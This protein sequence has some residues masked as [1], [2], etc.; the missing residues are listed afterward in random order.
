MRLMIV[1]SLALF[2]CLASAADVTLEWTP[3]TARVDGT[4]LPVS[5]IG[6]YSVRYKKK[7]DTAYKYVV[8]PDGKAVSYSLGALDAAEYQVSI[9]AFDVTGLYSDYSD[10]S[11]KISPAPAVPAS[12]KVKQKTVDVLAACRTAAQTCW[13]AV[14]GEWK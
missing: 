11:L 8:I 9:A 1:L 13:V 3:P 7:T 2:S 5:E 14:I 6:G 10:A 12:F 4:V